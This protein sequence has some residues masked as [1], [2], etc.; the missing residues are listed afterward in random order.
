M[1]VYKIT[2]TI[3]DKVYVGQTIDTLKKRVEY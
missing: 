3:N 1:I 2:N